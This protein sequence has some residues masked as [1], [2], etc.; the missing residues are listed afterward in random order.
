M[1]G[2][3]MIW[4]IL[5]LACALCLLL[6]LA[7][8]GTGLTRKDA[9]REIVCLGFPEYDWVRNI[10]GEEGD[11]FRVT[12]LLDKGVDL[13]SYQPSV[14]DIL[15]ISSCSL[16]LYTG[17]PSSA[18]MDD[19]LAENANPERKVLCF[20]DLLGDAVREEE[21]MEGMQEEEEEGEGEPDEH[22]WLSLRNAAVLVSGIAKAAAELDPA[23][24][25]VYEKNKEAYLEK[26]RELDAAYEKTV[27]E[28]EKPVL[29]FADRFPFRY[30]AEDYGIP[31]YAAFPGCS[32]ETEAS[33][34]TVA[35]LAAKT[36]E[37]GLPA[38]LTIE[39]SDGGIAR[40][41]AQ[42]VHNPD[43]KI[44]TMDSMQSVDAAA[45]RDGAGYLA[46]ME[47]NRRVLQEA[48]NP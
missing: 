21:W 30:L 43:L 7:A 28:A 6:P 35:F 16:L 15:K 9:G 1:R 17:G 41:V 47:N 22:V 18:W 27:R 45:I 37:L 31:C 32:A 13:H 8:C 26:L 38:I 39:G 3:A 25:A 29:L 2:K 5:A 20:L 24:A 40:T 14:Q 12:L 33:F 44:L 4:R 11:A 34:K 48:M 46:I 19:V 23:H 36:D 42:S 10:L